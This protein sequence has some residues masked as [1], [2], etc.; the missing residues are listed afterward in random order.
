MDSDYDTMS[1]LNA[2]T[3]QA[4]FAS[5]HS[6]NNEDLELHHSD[7]TLRLNTNSEE[8]ELKRAP[9]PCYTGR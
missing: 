1:H 3:I 5:R 7:S 4:N 6:I 9:M 2:A 8:M